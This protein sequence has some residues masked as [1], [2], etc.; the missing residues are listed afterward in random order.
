MKTVLLLSSIGLFAAASLY[1]SLLVQGGALGILAYAVWYLLSRG[2]PQ[3]RKEFL[4]A[5]QEERQDFLKA[6]KDLKGDKK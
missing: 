5:M 3:E 4:K 1:E 2:L 6:L